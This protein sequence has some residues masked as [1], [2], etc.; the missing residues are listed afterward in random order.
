M[1]DTAVDTETKTWLSPDA[2]F[3]YTAH[4]IVPVIGGISPE[5]EGKLREEDLQIDLSDKNFQ[6][7]RTAEELF[8]VSVNFRPRAY[9]RPDDPEFSESELKNPE[10][11][12]AADKARNDR[13]ARERKGD[14]LNA[15]EIEAAQ[16]AGRFARMARLHQRL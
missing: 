10:L 13:R 16:R 5:L 14:V 11:L 8:G 3:T 9:H 7:A 2:L 6:I 4:T 12:R 1:D 15:R